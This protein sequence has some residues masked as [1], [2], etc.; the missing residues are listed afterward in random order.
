VVW[1]AGTVAV[2]I[3]LGALTGELL[4]HRWMS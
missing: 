3:G 2:L 1:H 4:G